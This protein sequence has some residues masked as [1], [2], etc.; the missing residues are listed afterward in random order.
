MIVVNI[1]ATTVAATMRLAHKS[2]ITTFVTGEALREVIR[3]SMHEHG[4]LSFT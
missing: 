2:G 1:K 3:F 4:D